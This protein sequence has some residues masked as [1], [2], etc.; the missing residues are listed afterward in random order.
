M[1]TKE[2]LERI[3][4]T[5]VLLYNRLNRIET[6]LSRYDAEYFGKCE[7]NDYRENLADIS[8]SIV[9]INAALTPRLPEPA[10]RAA[11]PPEPEQV[12]PPAAPAP[13]WEALLPPW[14]PQAE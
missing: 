10:R 6:S 3:F 8:M 11:R 9:G 7:G 13:G 1:K 4:A 2:L 5:Q 14:S 12:A